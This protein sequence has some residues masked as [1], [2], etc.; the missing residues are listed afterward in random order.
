MPCLYGLDI[1]GIFGHYNRCVSAGKIL[2]NANDDNYKKAR[3]E[4]LIGYDRSVPKLR[5]AS[6][7]TGCAICRTHCPQ[8]INIPGEMR[9]IDLYA[10]QLKQKMEF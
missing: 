4:F 5:Q 6:H 8:R 2:K 1:P 9:R 3:R 7:C 10:E